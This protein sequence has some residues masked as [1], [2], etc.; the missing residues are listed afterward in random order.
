MLSLQETTILLEVFADS[1]RDGLDIKYVL[2][3]LKFAFEKKGKAEIITALQDRIHITGSIAEGM[4]VVLPDEN[5]IEALKAG[6]KLGNLDYV[7]QELKELYETRIKVSKGLVKAFSYPILNFVLI[8][9]MF[10]GALLFYIPRLKMVIKDIPPQKIPDATKM[11]IFL[12]DALRQHT[13]LYI[14]SILLIVLLLIFIYKKA[15][16]LLFQIP[17]IRTIFIYRENIMVYTLFSVFYVSGINMKKIF[18]MIISTAQGPIKKVFERTEIEVMNGMSLSKAMETGGA[19]KET[20]MYIEIGESTQKLEEDFKKLAKIES[21]KM[22]KQLNVLLNVSR[23]AMLVVI[24]GFV[25]VFFGITVLP[26]YD[27]L[28]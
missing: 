27:M 1:L 9:F 17:L 22:D 25:V 21:E 13:L 2:Q 7:F 4:R 5:L 8:F 11:L 15:K 12:S 28:R 23:N 24:A 20:V 26:I 3:R 14:A 18:E 16:P 6:E 19:D 10:T